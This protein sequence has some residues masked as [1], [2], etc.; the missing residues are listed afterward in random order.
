M[1]RFL[2]C[3]LI[4]LLW[5]G[6]VA[7]AQQLM[8]SVAPTVTPAPTAELA[9]DKPDELYLS[10]ALSNNDSLWAMDF[11]DYVE[12][13]NGGESAL[14]L[15]DFYLSRSAYDPY[16]C[17]LPDVLLEPDGYAAFRCD[18]VEITFNLP[19]DGCY[20]YLTRY[21]GVRC[22][23]A[24]LPAMEDN[25]W[26]M[27]QGLTTLPSPGYPNTAEGA[28][29]Y[30]ASLPQ[31]LV[32]NEV[33]ASN[34]TLLPVGEEYYDLIELYNA[35]D[36]PVELSAY[37]L[38][39]KKKEPFLWR[40][41]E[42]TLAPGECYVVYASGLGGEHASFKV[43]ADGETLYLTADDG[44]C[45]DALTVPALQPDIS[46]GRSGGALCFFDAP[47]PGRPNP[48]GA[49]GITPTPSASAPTG[50]Y[51]APFTVTLHGDG[52]LY[53]TLDGSA[54]TS[55]SALYTGESIPIGG[56]ATL[57]VVAIAE[58]QLPSDICTCQYLFGAERYELPIVTVSSAPG[59]VTGQNGIYEQWESKSREAAVNLA[60]IEDGQTR[61]SIDC[62]LKIHGQ[63]SRALSKKSFQVR[64]RGKYGQPTLSYKLFDDLAV[65]SFHAL[66]LRSGSEDGN[67][68]FL[69]DEFLTSLTAE[70][71]PDVLC[72][73]YKPVNL[74]I[75]GEYFGVYYL[76]ERITDDYAAAHLGGVARDIDMV[77]G[78]SRCE[79]G[80]ADDWLRLVRFCRRNS[81]AD[82][83]NYQTVAS[84]ICVESF[85]D[86]YIARAYTGDRDYANIRHC[87]S[88]GGDGRW[89]IVN[90]DL[91][92]GFGTDPAGLITYLGSVSDSSSQNTVV[93][94]AL[95]QNPRF[96]QQMIERLA[97]HLRTTYQPER[98]L[99]HLEAMVAQ[100][101]H[102]MPFNQER[103]G[104]SMEN[105]ESHLQYLRDF[106]RSGDSDRVSTMVRDAQR[107]FHLTDEE[108]TRYFG[109][110]W[111]AARE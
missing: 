60:L 1:L 109:D 11:C 52:A 108:M 97:M 95:L 103:W 19:K 70:S 33:V 5:N 72:Q 45:A 84:Q 9:S 94:N 101:R 53:Y 62:G 111:E 66:I 23:E 34:S 37:S 83:A 24:D 59:T 67:R 14:L 79:H 18:G 13:Y 69:R 89:R 85:M 65:Q 80:S 68:A 43:S 41:P 50:L 107:S 4:L 22:D 104:Y 54:P 35:G 76:R 8:P 28:A 90:F 10:E 78:W 21:D 61:F 82:E 88:A 36:A 16:Q 26:Q 49:T 12:L 17:R 38:S 74:F 93:I 63:G 58:N 55:E 73:A 46:Y 30:R 105:W 42:H 110:L 75:D 77:N 87:R 29:A 31:T 7:V 47:T 48:E 57:R 51:S 56:S 100:L 20:L 64:F 96:R 32:I 81:L 39:D 71:M 15:S 44:A 25:V 6:P 27:E 86:Y 92:W 2:A 102:D 91:D 99:A 40:L 3:L 106:V 98:V